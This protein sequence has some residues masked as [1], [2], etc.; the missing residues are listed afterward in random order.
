MRLPSPSD[1]FPSNH[2]ALSSRWAA[3]ANL[4]DRSACEQQQ[5]GSHSHG[6]EC[7]CSPLLG[8]GHACPCNMPGYLI[9]I[10][11]DGIAASTLMSPQC[12]GYM[13]SQV[14]KVLMW[15]R[16]SESVPSPRHDFFGRNDASGVTSASA[17]VS[18]SRT[19]CPEVD[20]S[21]F[22]PVA[23]GA[24]VRDCT[25]AFGLVGDRADLCAGEI[26]RVMPGGEKCCAAVGGYCE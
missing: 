7:P 9:G 17:G 11:Q 6:Q 18:S 21:G 12:A 3:A 23:G 1:V 24:R 5:A 25:E 22:V 2:S 8:Q 20:V 13:L 16:H 15:L 26:E 14:G 4:A 19:G 10:E